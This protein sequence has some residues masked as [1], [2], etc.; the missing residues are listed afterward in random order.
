MTSLA[1]DMFRNYRDWLDQ[2]RMPRGKRVALLAALELFADQGFDGTSTQAVADRAG[3]SQATIFKYFKTKQ[4]LLLAILQPVMDNFFPVYRDE[5]VAGIQRPQT[6]AEKV[7]FVVLD[8]YAF[9]KANRE[10]VKIFAVEMMTNAEIRQSFIKI[11]GVDNFATPNK[12]MTTF[13]Q[14]GE[15]RD[16]IQ[17]ADLIR[18]FIGQIVGYGIQTTYMP[19][20]D[21]NET[22]DLQ[23]ITEQLIRLIYK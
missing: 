6:L 4:D 13:R 20:S 9:F 3:I 23:R 18:S 17:A 14:T 15:L 7:H 16:D 11:V 1:T 10:A 19:V 2:Q 8:R 21:T 22:A 12:I 5:F